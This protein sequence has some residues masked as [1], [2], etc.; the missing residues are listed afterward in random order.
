MISDRLASDWTV[1]TR[2]RWAQWWALVTR[3]IT[4]FRSHDRVALAGFNP[5]G[6]SLKG[7]GD[8]FFGVILP[9]P[10][11][12]R[13]RKWQ[14]LARFE[15]EGTNEAKR[16]LRHVGGLY[17]Q[18]GIA[19]ARIEP[20]ET[21]RTIIDSKIYERPLVERHAQRHVPRRL[22]KHH[23]IPQF[24]WQ[25]FHGVVGIR[26]EHGTISARIQT[27]GECHPGRE[28]AVARRHV[29]VP[30]KRDRH[31]A[32]RARM[33]LGPCVDHSQFFRRSTQASDTILPLTRRPK[34]AVRPRKDRKREFIVHGQDVA[35][36]YRAQ[37]CSFRARGCQR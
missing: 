9:Y 13:R 1:R 19:H 15:T 21:H 32:P 36:D 16:R 34:A 31:Q 10:F 33:S 8:G 17:L 28:V 2:N 14:R 29:R 5:P 30:S 6:Q 24:L 7:S 22:G 26:N 35:C 37:K 3:L 27:T 20:G 23:E 11:L 25:P 4:K 18:G 12:Q